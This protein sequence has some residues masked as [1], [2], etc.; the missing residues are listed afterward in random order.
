MSE[1]NPYHL[2][3]AEPIGQLSSMT[4][5]ALIVGLIAVATSFGAKFVIDDATTD[6]IVSGIGSLITVISMVVAW[7][8]RLR[9]THVVDTN[10]NPV[11]QQQKRG[12]YSP[13]L[14]LPLMVFGV[15]CSSNTPPLVQV[16]Q[17]KQV[18]AGSLD[19]VTVAINTGQIKDRDTLLAIRAVR[20]ELDAAFVEATLK[21]E[22]GDKVGIKYVLDR[23]NLALERFLL[24]STKGRGVNPSSLNTDTP[25]TPQRFLL[26]FSPDKRS[27][28][29]W[30]R[31]L[32]PPLPANPSATTN[33]SWLTSN[34][35]LL[36]HATTLQ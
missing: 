8:G 7:I 29:V 23:I 10:V 30:F 20:A 28:P 21:A 13:L 12:G 5:K 25:W 35:L 11:V 18:Y 36:K 2:D 31:P 15:G 19:A 33:A 24:L 32:R 17:A 6:K 14:L 26:S 3:S 4:I 1:K 22:T 9:A 27:S 16:Y 34:W